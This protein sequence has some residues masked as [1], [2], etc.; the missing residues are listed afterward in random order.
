V[1]KFEKK[2]MEDMSQ[3]WAKP[4]DGIKKMGEDQVSGAAAE[5]SSSIPNKES[6]IIKINF[7]DYL[8]EA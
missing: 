7:I 6:C 5:E 8:K 4:G 1:E 3:A 2:R